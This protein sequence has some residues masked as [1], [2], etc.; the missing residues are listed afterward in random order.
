MLSLVTVYNRGEK[1]K[2]LL[3]AKGNKHTDGCLR[4]L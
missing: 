2:I 3:Y 4:M 1:K